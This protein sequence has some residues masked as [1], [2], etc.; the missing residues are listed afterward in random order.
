[1]RHDTRCTVMVV[2]D[3]VELRYVL[4][5]FLSESGF[6]VLQVGTADDAAQLLQNGASVNVVF[7]DVNMPGEMDGIGLARWLRCNRPEI[8]V[9]LT[10]GQLQFGADGLCDGGSIVIKPF[11]LRSVA[12]RL[13]NVCHISPPPSLVQ[14]PRAL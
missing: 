3:D 7:S 1:M 10:S 11:R 6:H 2:E 4:S 8:K 12:T 14:S 5:E 9:V 13:L